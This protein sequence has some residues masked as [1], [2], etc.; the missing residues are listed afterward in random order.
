MRIGYRFNL[1]EELREISGI[2]LRHN[3]INIALLVLGAMLLGADL[4]VAAWRIH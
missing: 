1:R 2:T 3:L 4:L